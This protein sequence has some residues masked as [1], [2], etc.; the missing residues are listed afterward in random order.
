MKRPFLIAYG[1]LAY[2]LF[3]ASFFYL[4]GFLQDF[5]VPKA[6]NDG[7]QTATGLALS[8]NVGLVF[9]FGFFHSLMARDSFKQ[10]WTRIVPV[11]AERSTYVLQSALFL[12]LA[13][14]QW[15]P[16]PQVLWHVEGTL[17][18]AL[19]GLFCVGVAVLLI[20]TFLIDHF[21]LF[22]LK[23]VWFA[24]AGRQMPAAEFK[25][26]L[27]YRIVRH[28]MQLGVLITVFS[29]PHMTVGHLVFAAS[30]AAYVLIGLW[31]E[32]RSLVR[33]FGTAY[34]DYQ[35]TTPMLLP[36][37]LPARRNRALLKPQSL[38]AEAV[39]AGEQS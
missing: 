20:S 13:M 6:I 7:V 37:L 38:S 30:M 35:R 39:R 9:L 31:F 16:M 12:A 17:A 29:T 36:R 34:E 23:Q 33:E 8:I 24:G 10:R 1:L 19:V 14:W 18:L 21:E 25:T 2:A 32:E 11:D 26:P 5:G 15:R 27:L 22:G 28:P 3:N 4:A